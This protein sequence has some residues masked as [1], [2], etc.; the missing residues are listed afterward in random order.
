MPTHSQAAFVGSRSPTDAALLAASSPGLRSST[1]APSWRLLL[2]LSVLSVYHIVL[3]QAR[4][5]YQGHT[6]P[7]IASARAHSTPPNHPCPYHI[8]ISRHVTSYMVGAGLA[9]ALEWLP[10]SYSHQQGEP[11]PLV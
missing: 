3:C 7:R 5:S 1:V 11:V 10:A 6:I 4:S 2:V 9:P 8:R